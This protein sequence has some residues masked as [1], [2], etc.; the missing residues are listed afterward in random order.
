MCM[1]T[2]DFTS[3]YLKPGE[4]RKNVQLGTKP[5]LRLFDKAEALE[6]GGAVKMT[7][8]KYPRLEGRRLELAKN[9]SSCE[10]PSRKMSARKRTEAY[11]ASKE[12]GAMAPANTTQ[13][14]MDNVYADMKDGLAHAASAHKYDESPSTEH[15]YAA[16]DS[17]YERFLSYQQKDFDETVSLCWEPR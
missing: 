1:E 9:R 3:T 15:V 10:E 17:D 7:V 14:L 5:R 11:L 8:K 2:M 12:P 6:H 16:L 13:Y 4:Q